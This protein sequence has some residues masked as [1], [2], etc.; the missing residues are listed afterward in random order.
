[1]YRQ[2]SQAEIDTLKQQGCV[3]DNWENVEVSIS[4]SAEGIS[5]VRFA[6]NIKLGTQRGNVQIDEG[7]LKPA[8]I[9]NC[10]IEN[11]TIGENVFLSNVGSLINYKLGNQ[12]VIENVGSVVVSGESAFGNGHE[13]DVLN[14]GG[15]RELPIFDKLSAQIAYLLVIYRHN[16]TLIEKLKKLVSEY[17]ETKKSRVGEI[18]DN[19][20]IQHT[21]SIKNVSIG[22]FAKIV[23]ASKLVEGTIN[24]RQQAPVY[25]GEEVVAEDFIVL[26]GSKIDGSAILSSTFIG[27][28]VKVGRQFSAENTTLFANSEAFHGEACSVFAGPYTVTHHKSTLLIAGMFSFYN[29]GSGSNQSNHMYKL[30]P[31]HQ[32]IV[33][34]GSKTGSLSYMLWPCRVGAFSVVMNK[35]AGNFDTTELPFSYIS[36]SDGKSVLT[37]AMNLFTVGTARDSKKWPTRDRRTDSEKLDLI[38]FELFNPYIVQKI[39]NG[40]ELLSSLHETTPKS[41]DFAKH[42]GVHINRLMLRTSKRYYDLAINVFLTNQI[43]EK[44]INKSYHS[45]N[46]VIELLKPRSKSGGEKWIDLLGMIVERNAIEKLIQSV[47]NEEINTIEELQNGFITIHEEYADKSYSWSIVKLKELQ[48]VDISRISK[49][50]LISLVSDWKT[51]SIKFKNMILKDAEKEFDQ[52]SRIGFGI[53]GDEKENTDDFEAIRGTYNNNSF[54][55][56]LKKEIDEIDSTFNAVME[57]LEKLPE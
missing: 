36:V 45:L 10:F 38:S 13:I 6:G 30:G 12:V 52:L 41:K 27:Q 48:N 3:A 14:E 37:P 55:I 5:N 19:T 1:M 42:K 34:R 49:Q 17:V 21:K 20:I 43:V 57:R 56:G 32:G 39:I 50:E 22:P 18:G 40:S 4:F 54:I 25:I 7:I 28:G 24:S 31:I 53:D 29:A 16:T 47:C 33:E 23:G 44:L 11:C 35:H 15:G 46:E 26:S 9:R 8:T 51:N 2:L